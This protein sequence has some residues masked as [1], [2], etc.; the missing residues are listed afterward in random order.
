VMYRGHKLQRSDLRGWVG[1]AATCL[2]VALVVGACGSSA[3]PPPP[4]G[5]PPG[6]KISR[7][8]THYVVGEACVVSDNGT[9][10]S[11]AALLCVHG[12]LVTP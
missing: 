8:F 4:Q 6:I 7:H 5:A 1:S 3:T 10:M 12:H 11:D 9:Y 2:G